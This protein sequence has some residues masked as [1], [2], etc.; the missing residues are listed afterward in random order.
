MEGRFRN[1]LVGA[2]ILVSLAVIFVPMI[3]TG[4]GELDLKVRGPTIPPEPDFGSS[5]LLPKVPPPNA[6]DVART[7]PVVV[8]Q[9]SADG[10]AESVA[11][12]APA[13]S[14]APEVPVIP[15]EPVEAKPAVTETVAAGV[16]AW[17]VQV[18]SFESKKSAFTLRDQLRAKGFAAYVEAVKSGSRDVY[19]VRVGPELQQEL[20]RQLLERIAK[21]TGTKGIVVKHH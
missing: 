1:R 19:R 11:P 2:V 17:A 7:D 21:D 9:P 14:A 16:P 15:P 5:N 3:L 12:L 8:E 18:G 6:A 10:D 4:E 20:A 13:T